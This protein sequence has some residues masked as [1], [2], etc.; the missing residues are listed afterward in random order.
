MC[1]V[2]SDPSIEEFSVIRAPHILQRYVL[3]WYVHARGLIARRSANDKDGVEDED[4]G[5][6]EPGVSV[7]VSVFVVGWVGCC[8]MRNGT[9]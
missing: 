3:L 7:S 9:K 5:W 4:A 2:R 6:A 1:E 8:G